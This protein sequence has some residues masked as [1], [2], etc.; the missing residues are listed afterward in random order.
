ML[1][2]IVPVYNEIENLERCVNSICKQ[3]YSDIE[4]ILVDDG[5]TDGSS[6]LCDKF[7]RKDKRIKVVHKNN[8]GLSSARN[9]GL[10][11]ATGEFIGFVDSDDWISED[12]YEYLIGLQKKYNA[13]VCQIEYFQTNNFIT[14]IPQKEHVQSYVE[15]DAILK[16]YLVD[17]MKAVKSYPVNTKVYRRECFKT[18]RFPVGQL[19]EDV[20]TNFDI[21]SQCHTYVVSN[22]ICYFYYMNPASITRGK[23]IRKD[24]DYIEVGKQIVERTKNNVE[25]KSLGK[26]TYGRFHFMCI[27]KMIKY[28][29]E[30]EI[31]IEEVG[32]MIAIVRENIPALLGS[33]MKI[34]RKLVMLLICLN[35]SLT[36]Y[37][38]KRKRA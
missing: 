19:Y 29:C 3:S 17:G 30:P 25:L 32:K 7:A 16:Q 12:M 36:K 18:I 13:D 21:L 8:G 23:F 35:K 33:K 1:S 24:F 4:I 28:D 27:C 22:R 5:S 6:N 2:I 11:I 10:D 38:I 34:S 15:K 37:V 26:M 14:N 31:N 9:A 20:V